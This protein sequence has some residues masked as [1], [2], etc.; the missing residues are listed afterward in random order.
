MNYQTF[1]KDVIEHI[2]A[3]VRNGQKVVLQPVIKNNGI[4]YDGLIILDPILN[5]SP[6]IYLN[7]YYHRYLNGVSME[8]IY[9]DILK[10]Y[11]ENLPKKDFDV[12]LF[13]DFQK[14]KP[15]ITFKLVNK[16][17][18][19]EILKDIP[20]VAF[21]DLVLIFVCTITDFMDDYATI[22]IHN[23]HMSLWNATTEELYAIAMENTP[24][25]LPYRFENLE[26]V[27]EHLENYSCPVFPG[28]NMYILTNHLKIYG[29]TCIIYPR[30]LKRIADFLEDNLIIIPSSIHEV[31]IIPEHSAK[32]EY[33][34]E[35]FRMM[36][37]EINE[38]ELTDDE[39]LSDHAYLFER[40]TGALTF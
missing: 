28:L 8:D 2:S 17:K 34:M 11:H 10:T 1:M 29:S 32:P 13:K 22:L 15:R 7:P 24:T 23:Q 25:L 9:D 40:E 16:E 30:L 12:S 4:V 6:T 3:S 37:A 5:I 18:N 38:T 27:L 21:Q 33:T 26:N 31:L 36:I 20:H 14:A 19:K 35:D 39:V